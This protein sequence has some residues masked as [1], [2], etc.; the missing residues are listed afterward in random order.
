MK[1]MTR[2]CA[3]SSMLNL[4]TVANHVARDRFIVKGDHIYAILKNNLAI[5]EN[6]RKTE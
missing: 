4:E 2:T 5:F 6:P 3:D 1:A